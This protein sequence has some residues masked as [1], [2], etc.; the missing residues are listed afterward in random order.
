MANLE[1]VKL[2]RQGAKAIDEWRS[3]N[4]GVIFDLHKAYLPSAIQQKVGVLI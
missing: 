1:H 3:A 4:P 2:V